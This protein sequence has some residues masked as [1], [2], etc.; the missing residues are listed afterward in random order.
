VNLCNN[1]ERFIFE[2]FQQFWRKMRKIAFLG[3]YPLKKDYPS[4][5]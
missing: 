4:N 1:G 5:N 3:G 2:N